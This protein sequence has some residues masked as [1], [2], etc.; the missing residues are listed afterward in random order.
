M[1]YL[2]YKQI[3][4]GIY[5][6]ESTSTL[7]WVCQCSPENSPWSSEGQHFKEG[8]QESRRQGATLAADSGIS[9]LGLGSN[10]RGSDCFFE[11]QTLLMSAVKI[12]YEICNA[13]KDN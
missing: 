9:R 3:L 2:F 6:K 7:A 4:A 5:T 1:N 12:S 13:I 8:I 10:L 11:Y